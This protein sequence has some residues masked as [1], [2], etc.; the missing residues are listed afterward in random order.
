[1]I[2]LIYFIYLEYK[3]KAQH[4]KLLCVIKYM[5]VHVLYL[6]TATFQYFICLKIKNNLNIHFLVYKIRQ[7]SVSVITASISTTFPYYTHRVTQ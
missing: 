6:L 7:L 5:I 1:M 4:A 3:I 2:G